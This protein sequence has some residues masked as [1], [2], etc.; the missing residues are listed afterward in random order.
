[1]PD[2]H[3]ERTGAL[4]TTT[5]EQASPSKPR[6]TPQILAEQQ[7]P[8]KA[9]PPT[10]VNVLVPANTGQLTP[11]FDAAAFRTKLEQWGTLPYISIEFHGNDGI[12]N[13]L[14]GS[15]VDDREFAVPIEKTMRGFIRFHGPG[16]APDVEMSCISGGSPEI[17]RAELGDTDP[18]KWEI[19]LDG[20]PRDPWQEE[21]QLP[22]IAVDNGDLYCFIARN[23]VSIIAV[24]QLLGRYHYNPNGRIGWTPVLKLGVVTYFNKRFKCEKPKPVLGVTRWIAPNDGGGGMLPAKPPSGTNEFGDTVPF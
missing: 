7:N 21:W 14:D 17:V 19:G 18:A 22:L 2:N 9:A 10:P 15:S 24:R 1:M 5:L 4:K 8:P 3:H 20:H 11:A 13:T 12:F 16:N 23:K 6:T